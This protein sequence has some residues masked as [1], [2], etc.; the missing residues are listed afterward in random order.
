[1]FHV[2]FYKNYGLR[3]K[4]V[5]WRVQYAVSRIHN[6][7]RLQTLVSTSGGS[8]SIHHARVIIGQC[9]IRSSCELCDLHIDIVLNGSFS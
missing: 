6:A 7:D 9:H 2:S 8:K 5:L 4:C 3:N 1:M